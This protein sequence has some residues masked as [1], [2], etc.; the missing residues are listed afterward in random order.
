MQKTT[1]QRKYYAVQQIGR[2]AHVYIFGDIVT[3][4]LF[5]GE[6]SAYSFKEEL[7]AIDADVIHVHIDSYGGAVSE[8][9]SIYNT[10][11][12]HPARIVT[13]ADGFVASAAI[14]PFMAGDERIASNLSA[15]FFHQV[16]VSAA[17]NAD[18]LRAAADEADKL[19]EIGLNAFTDNGVDADEIRALEKAETWL[20]ADEALS[21]GI[22]TSIV[23]DAAPREQQSVKREIIQRVTGRAAAQDRPYVNAQGETPAAENAGGKAPKNGAQGA[24]KPN[25][26]GKP[27]SSVMAL[28]KDT[29][30]INHN[31]D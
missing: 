12:E 25:D 18:D 24:D 15:F 1:Q 17:G 28:F 21:L 23:A 5:D 30:Y 10:L 29:R 27:V 4:Q 19:N 2:E 13:H 7:N 31:N 14:Y 9:W 20:D 11:R 22:A 6:T 26:A 8:G 16:L 3:W